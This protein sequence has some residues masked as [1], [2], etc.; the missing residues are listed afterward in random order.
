[1]AIIT[2]GSQITNE[3]MI[4]TRDELINYMDAI[5]ELILYKAIGIRGYKRSGY[6]LVC[7]NDKSKKCKT[8]VYE[9]EKNYQD[10]SL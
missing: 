10:C 3:V 2:T 8:F 1:M 4:P 6:V 5:H 9:F 7:N